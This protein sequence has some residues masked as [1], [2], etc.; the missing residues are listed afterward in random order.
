MIVSFK[1]MVNHTIFIKNYSV[2]LYCHE[3]GGPLFVYQ[4][5]EFF[6]EFAG[7]F[8]LFFPGAVGSNPLRPSC[9]KLDSLHFIA[10]YFVCSV[11]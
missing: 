4:C 9:K 5:L 8:P 2:V 11:R 1:Q 3:Y 7:N 10:K 6:N